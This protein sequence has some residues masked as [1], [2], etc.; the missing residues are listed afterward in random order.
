M[1][2]TDNP[3]TDR[4]IRLVVLDMAGTTVADGGLVERAFEA[5]A[6]ELGVAPGS[7]DHEAK[8][9]YVRATMGESKISV[10]RHLF[11]DE[12][13]ARRANTVF[14]KA[15]GALIGEGL[16]TPVDGAREAIGEL[17]ADGRTVVLTTGFARATQD[18]ILDALGW[19]DLAA[20]T[21]CP[22]DAGGRGRPYPDMV[23]EAFLRTRA[24]DDVRQV[25]VAG[26]TAYDMASGVHAGAGAVVGVLT[27]AHE[28]EA[29]R[30][31]GATHVIASVSEL[32]AL[33]R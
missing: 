17:T 9:A 15:Y 19:R 32:P 20:L 24:T 13:S 7:A 16:V 21:L 30:E 4:D 8:L 6:A 29:L 27:G 33:L 3:T 25:A 12:D 31:A 14:E 11:G 28:R 22:A 10:F 5:A 2:Q 1:P 18:A 26:D 23:L